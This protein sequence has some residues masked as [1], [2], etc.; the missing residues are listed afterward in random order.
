MILDHDAIAAA[1][2][3]RASAHLRRM[4]QHAIAVALAELGRHLAVAAALTR[5]FRLGFDAGFYV[6]GEGFNG[7]YAP[8]LTAAKYEAMRDDGYGD[9]W[10]PGCGRGAVP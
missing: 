5:A 1:A 9:D 4:E 6:T 7:E 8:R 2:I 3:E 10:R